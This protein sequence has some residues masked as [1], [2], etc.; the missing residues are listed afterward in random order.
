MKEAKSSSQKRRATMSK[1][2]AIDLTS[3]QVSYAVFDAWGAREIYL[4]MSTSFTTM[5]ECSCCV[6]E[7]YSEYDCS[8]RGIKEALTCNRC[9]FTTFTEAD[10]ESHLSRR[11]HIAPQAVSIEIPFCVTCHRGFA[12]FADL[13][14]HQR[15]AKHGKYRL[16]CEACGEVFKTNKLKT[17]TAQKKTHV[18][19]SLGSGGADSPKSETVTAGHD[20]TAQQCSECHKIFNSALA[21]QLHLLWHS[22]KQL[23]QDLLEFTQEHLGCDNLLAKSCLMEPRLGLQV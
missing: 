12:S 8:L 13:E 23:P 5:N 14:W 6:C 4:A 2:D 17:K 22:S 3:T 18:C 11:C 16:E 15:D 1:W 7:H 20:S 21:L 9:S 10:M 19:E